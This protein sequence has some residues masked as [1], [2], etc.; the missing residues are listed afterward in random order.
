MSLTALKDRVPSDGAIPPGQNYFL[1]IKA[2]ER[3]REVES[4]RWP[5]SNEAPAGKAV[6]RTENTP[7]KRE[8]IR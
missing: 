8:A 6:I 2:H 1:L 7:A 3:G 5:N 4:M